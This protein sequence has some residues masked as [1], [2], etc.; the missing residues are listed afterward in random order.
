M[1]EE[2]I[3]IIIRGIPGSGKTTFAKLLVDNDYICTADDYHIINGKYI[4]KQENIAAAHRYCQQKCQMLM[5]KQTSKI[6]IANTSV[7]NKEIQA[8]YDLAKQY[9][10]KVFS[11]IVENRHQGKSE[12][13]VPDETL[14]KMLQNFDIKLI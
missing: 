12:H 3:L 13:N 10:Y 14:I 5:K 6:V 7:T 2:K 1:K 8:Y 11:I 9:D 4:W